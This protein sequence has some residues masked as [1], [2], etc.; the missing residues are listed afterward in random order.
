MAGLNMNVT[1]FHA[2]TRMS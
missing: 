1:A 2:V